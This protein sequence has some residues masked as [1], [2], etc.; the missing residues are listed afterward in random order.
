MPDEEIGQP[1][2]VGVLWFERGH[3][4]EVTF[5]DGK[6]HRRQGKLLVATELAERAGLQI[7]P[8]PPGTVR[9][10]NRKTAQP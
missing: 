3:Q 7:A 4:F 10:G 1:E 6:V 8:T 2:I 5:V 9:W